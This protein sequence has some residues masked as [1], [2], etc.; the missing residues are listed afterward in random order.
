MRGLIKGRKLFLGLLFLAV[1]ALLLPV[2]KGGGA[3]REAVAD[4]KD[5]FVE[6]IYRSDSDA[7]KG[8][9]LEPEDTVTVDGTAYYLEEVQYEVLEKN[10]LPSESQHMRI[11][12]S[13]PFTGEPEKN[14]PQE[15]IRA[16]G[17]D[18]YLKSY[19]ILDTVIDAREQPVA[20]VIR[21]TSLPAKSQVP[22]AADLKIRDRL[23]GD[24]VMV[25]V[26]L[27]S[28]S[29]GEE[30][31][32]QGFEFSVTIKDYGVGKFDLNGMEVVIDEENPLKGYEKELLDMIGVSKES[33]RIKKISWEGEP[34]WENG[35]LCRGLKAEGDWK[36]RDC[37]AVYSGVANLPEAEAKIIQA[38]YTD[39]EPAGADQDYIYT[40]KATARYSNTLERKKS[41]IRPYLVTV[42]CALLAISSAFLLFGRYMDGRK[43]EREYEQLRQYAGH[44]KGTAGMSAGGPGEAA[45]VAFPM[46]E[47]EVLKAINPEYAAWLLIPDTEIHYPVVWPEDNQTYLKRT[48]GGEKR[49]CGALFFEASRSPFGG[50]NT[51]IYG[52][53]MRSEAMFG[54]LKKYL[55]P[56]YGKTHR[57]FYI[58]FG[59][60]W[61][62][63]QIFAVYRIRPQDISP[64]EGAFASREALEEFVQSCRDRSLYALEAAPEG[65]GE[66]LTLSTCHGSGERLIVQGW[67]KAE[68]E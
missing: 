22:E 29:W 68:M 64:Y 34:Y 66:I 26:P 43:G 52:H 17:K 44:M 5:L 57:D 46:I 59:G 39:L 60:S 41:G 40:M 48:F 25:Q 30:R 27:Q 7:P 55:E 67:R 38:V 50:F 36:V 58:F 10:P 1:L 62:H 32:E 2:L 24:E 8:Q 4:L 56:D 13:A 35:R 3:G 11:E 21:Y 31:W 65:T 47:E 15:K 37:E 54:G 6:T 28:V 18:W 33:Y 53:N 42:V 20:D 9:K 16:E 63:Y 12:T 19:E 45:K 23:T 61:R 49:A 51:V 14:L